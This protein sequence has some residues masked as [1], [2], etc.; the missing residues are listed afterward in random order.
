[1]SGTEFELGLSN[2]QTWLV[3]ASEKLTFS[4]TSD[5][6]LTNTAAS[7]DGESI[8]LRL[9]YVPGSGGASGGGSGDSGGGGG[10]GGGDNGGEDI[11]AMVLRQHADVYPVSA[12]VTWD[13]LKAADDDAGHGDGGAGGWGN[14]LATLK[15]RW[16]TRSLSGSAAKSSSALLMLAL[17]HQAKVMALSSGTLYG[18]DANRLEYQCMK[19]WMSG[20][21][22]G[23]TTAAETDDGNGG[24]AGSGN[25][26]ESEWAMEY[27]LSPI[28]W[29]AP[30]SIDHSEHDDHH[31][32]TS[33]VTAQLLTDL[34]SKPM[35]VATDPYG[36]GKEVAALARLALIA[37]EVGRQKVQDTAVD[38]LKK[39]LEG[40]LVGEE[41]SGGTGGT[42][43]S[44]ASHE[45]GK[46]GATGLS[47]DTRVYDGMGES[48]AEVGGAGD[49]MVIEVS[50]KTAA[51]TAALVYD[52][53]WGGL[54]TL[55]GV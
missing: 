9:A 36:F 1:M 33:V 15:F 12:V 28:S 20:V 32:H 44:E 22:T 37:H 41:S 5:A 42:G 40:W 13:V 47:T 34:A 3:F 21:A 55:K 54:P 31:E 6:V 43:D 29:S 38:N 48:N 18:S 8:V 46:G 50:L 39:A 24:G 2:G 45:K 49:E 52:E 23:L 53:T 4:W 7:T 14:D 19:G 27:H 51:G 11:A 26:G 30:R 25:A 35:P 10:G 16:Q 17:P